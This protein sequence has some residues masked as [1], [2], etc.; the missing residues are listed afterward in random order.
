MTYETEESTSFY[1]KPAFWVIFIS[2]WLVFGVIVVALVVRSFNNFRHEHTTNQNAKTPPTSGS[3]KTSPKS[4]AM[5]AAGMLAVYHPTGEPAEQHLSSSGTPMLQWRCAASGMSLKFQKLIFDWVS[6]TAIS[7]QSPAPDQ[8]LCYIEQM[9]FKLG[10]SGNRRVAVMEFYPTRED[11]IASDNSLPAS[12]Y[13]VSFFPGGQ[14]QLTSFSPKNEA[15]N[16]CLTYLS[17]LK[18][19]NCLGS[20]YADIQGDNENVKDRIVSSPQVT[21]D[22][23]NI[24]INREQNDLG[25][26]KSESTSTTGT[27]DTASSL[28]NSISAKSDDARSDSDTI[29]ASAINAGRISGDS[30]IYPATAKAARIEGS[31]LLDA[32]ISG[33]G[34][35]E[36]VTAISGSPLL[37]AAAVKAVRT[38]RYKPYLINGQP[39]ELR[40]RIKLDFSLPH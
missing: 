37:E 4:G 12:Y 40:T 27:T 25:N 2:I 14:W 13:M 28:A 20:A 15:S 7:D 19:G 26:G 23:S 3:S 18:L 10:I 11:K 38:W 17:A 8:D 33:D 34:A 32:T 21:P 9:N 35:V 1:K 6:A 16:T 36:E 39:V 22:V 29:S 24:P 31:V 5:I 30:P